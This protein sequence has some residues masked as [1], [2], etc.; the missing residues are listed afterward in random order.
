[1]EKKALSLFICTLLC[2]TGKISS[3]QIQQIDPIDVNTSATSTDAKLTPNITG[4]N[5]SIGNIYSPNLYDGSVNITI[6]FFQ[7]PT[8]AGNLGV[9]ISY[10]TKGVKVD[11]MAPPVGLHWD[12]NAGG[13]IYRQM[14]GI[15]DELN[16]DQSSIISEPIPIFLPEG[17]WGQVWGQQGNS[18]N[19]PTTYLDEE[20]DDFIVSVGNLSFT[21]NIGV[22][23]FVFTHPD[24]RVKIDVL[25]GGVPVTQ[26]PYSETDET[27]DLNFHITDEQGNQYWFEN[28]TE[29]Y[30][31]FYNGKDGGSG[32]DPVARLGYISS[33]VISKITLANGQSIKYNYSWITPWDVLYKSYT[34]IERSGYANNL[35]IVGSDVYRGDRIPNISSIEYPDNHFVSFTYGGGEYPSGRCDNN[36]YILKEVKVSSGPDT[37]HYCLTHTYSIAD[38]PGYTGSSEIP[39]STNCNNIFGSNLSDYDKRYLRLI[40]KKITIKGKDG[41]YSEPYYS[42]EYDMSTRLPARM[43]GSQD[44]FGYYNGKPVPGVDWQLTIPEHMPLLGSTT[45]YGAD[46]S[47][48][49]EK[50]KAGLLKKVNNAYGGSVRFDYEGHLLFSPIFVAVGYT[51]T[52]PGFLGI[53]ADDGV[54]IKKITQEDKFYPDNSMQTLFTYSGGQRFLTGGYFNIPKSKNTSGNFDGYYYTGIYL[55]PHQFVNGSNHGYSW[56]TSETKDQSGNLLSKSITHFSNL[57]DETATNGCR[58][59]LVGGHDRHYFQWPFADRQYLRD[60]ELG[61]PLDITVYD[62]NNLILSKVINTYSWGIDTVS[63]INKLGNKKT[64]KVINKA[65]FY[66]SS[67]NGYDWI[68]NYTPLDSTTYRPYTGW[69]DL[70]KT[71]TRKYISDNAYIQDTVTYQYDEERHNLVSTIATNSKGEQTMLKQV[72]NYDVSGPDVA[73]GIQ[74]GTTLYNMTAAGLEKVVSLERWKLPAT[75]SWVHYNDRLIDASITRYDYNDGKILTKGLYTL[76]AGSPLSYTDYTGMSMGSP[77]INAFGKVREA[78]NGTQPP[79]Y[80][81][82]LSKVTLFDATGNPLETKLMGMDQYKAM[83]WDSTTGNKIAEAVNAHNN[84]IGYTGFEAYDTE[85][86]YAESGTVRSGNMVF[87]PESITNAGIIRSA[88]KLNP[89]IPLWCKLYFDVATGGKEY[90][91]TF[92]C[93]DGVPVFS[94]NNGTNVNVSQLYSVGDWK[95]YQGRFTPISGERMSF[96]TSAQV[97]VDEVRIFPSDAQMQTW[98]YEPL[99]GISAVS[100]VRGRITYYEYDKLGRLRIVRNQEGKILS[101]SLYKVYE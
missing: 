13:G 74:V 60:W 90:T 30:W 3:A 36:N 71:E 8:D 33:W 32:L 61:L 44:Y 34:A 23:G 100:D 65:N 80:F 39:E 53:D 83:L 95:F 15:P 28:S 21:F 48:V 19:L 27:V 69:A 18:G 17:K 52:A 66:N 77:I 4:I 12:L 5:S 45:S 54:R 50:A 78:Y 26:I 51:P 47:C 84:E 24:R 55:S 37:I 35:P 9:S 46:R 92:W 99:F 14:K 88:Y 43:S 79:D 1:M 25:V 59:L 75:P 82:E 11:E 63:T 41:I 97:Y 68:D 2:T 62:Q 89:A 16:S 73:G 42:F 56:V 10:N 40:L 22:G 20:F 7:Y 86:P 67:N 70:V 93:K 81:K 72:Y 6:P 85:Y 38:K 49:A 96:S 87:N 98:V 91:V 76:T 94:G 57:S 58:Y 64:L 101:E 31:E 29:E